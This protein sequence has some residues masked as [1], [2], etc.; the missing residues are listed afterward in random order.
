MYAMV[1]GKKGGGGGVSSLD[2][3]VPCLCLLRKE[4]KGEE[5]KLFLLA[6]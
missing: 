2:G 5:E 3:S 6:K 4:K 1:Q